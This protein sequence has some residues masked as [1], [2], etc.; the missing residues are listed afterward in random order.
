LARKIRDLIRDL[1]QAGFVDRGGRGSHRNFVHA[2]VRKPVTISGNPG[3][4]AL[5]YQEKAVRLAVKES[6]R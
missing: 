1:E 2:K 6:I 4:D 3:D 5:Q